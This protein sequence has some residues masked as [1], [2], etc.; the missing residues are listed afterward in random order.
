MVTVCMQLDKS[1]TCKQGG[2]LYL[3]P[4]INPN[5]HFTRPKTPAREKVM[6]E[7]RK[8]QKRFLEV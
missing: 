6:E 7:E 2:E 8:S 5:T 3:N 4:M 1:K